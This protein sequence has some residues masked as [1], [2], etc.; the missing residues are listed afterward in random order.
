R[1]R[2]EAR[3]GPS[4]AAIVEGD[5]LQ[6]PREHR[7]GAPPGAAAEAETHDQEHGW[8]RAPAL[9]VQRDVPAGGCGGAGGAAHASSRQRALETWAAPRSRVTSADS[10]AI[11]RT[12]STSRSR[13]SVRRPSEA[14]RMP[15]S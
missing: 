5:D 10:V 4:D 8:A 9:P 6:V 12:G 1:E 2:G 13:A 14:R 7:H 3:L 15:A 11:V